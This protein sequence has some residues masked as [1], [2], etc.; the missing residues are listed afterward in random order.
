MTSGLRGV[1]RYSPHLH[2][3][4]ASADIRELDI[5]MSVDRAAPWSVAPLKKHRSRSWARLLHPSAFA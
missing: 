4:R 5:V 3:G 1:P 2:L